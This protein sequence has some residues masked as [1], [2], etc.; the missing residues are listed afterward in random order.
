VPDLRERA[1]SPQ[2]S[3]SQ[4]QIPAGGAER[5]ALL[6]E[7]L[8]PI[9]AEAIASCRAA[10]Y[11]WLEATAAEEVLVRARQ[12]GHLPS[13]AVGER[14]AALA[15][16]AAQRLL[17]AHMRTE[18]AE[19]VA[20]AVGFAR[21]GETWRPRDVR[22]EAL[23]PAPPDLLQLRRRACRDAV[24]LRR[25][26]GLSADRRRNRRSSPGAPSCTA[27]APA[28]RLRFT[29]AACATRKWSCMS[30]RGNTPLWCRWGQSVH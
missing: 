20:R 21:G 1:K 26:R 4:D 25:Q 17:V 3:T 5:E 7:L 9:I 19:G 22:R 28:P 6:G 12:A 13:E 10:H 18:E 16:R 24:E 2:L 11:A 27:S 15:G 23:R 30:D 29:Q 14:A 8:E